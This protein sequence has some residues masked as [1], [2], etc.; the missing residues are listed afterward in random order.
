MA[1]SQV[2]TKDMDIEK[3]TPRQK[4]TALALGAI[5]GLED[6][7]SAQGGMGITKGRAK[8]ATRL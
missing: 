2:L 4:H 1:S 3:T 5:Q 8:A 7:M 6:M